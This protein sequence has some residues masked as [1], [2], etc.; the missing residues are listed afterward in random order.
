M[1][2]RS[3]QLFLSTVRTLGFPIASVYANQR[4][5]ACVHV[6]S[7]THD[8]VLNVRDLSSP[9]NKV[10]AL[11]YFHGHMGGV[12]KFSALSGLEDEGKEAARCGEWFSFVT[13]VSILRCRACECL[14]LHHIAM[15]KS[16]PHQGFIRAGISHILWKLPVLEV[17]YP[18]LPAPSP[19]CVSIAM[20]SFHVSSVNNCSFWKFARLVSQSIKLVKSKGDIFG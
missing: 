3:A 18:G 5:H 15:H 8:L 20:S 13:A 7:S 10:R 17:V 12:R 9:E 16:V 6:A 19:A 14:F 4:V 2:I 1:R 11:F